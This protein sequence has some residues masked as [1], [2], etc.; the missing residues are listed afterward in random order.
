MRPCRC[1]AGDRRESLLNAA[2]IPK[3][4]EKCSFHTFDASAS[5]EHK[6]V[7]MRLQRWVKDFPVVEHGWLLTGPCGVGKT[8]LAV[9]VIREL[10]EAKEISC[11]FYEFGD[12]L[13]K[14]QDSYNPVSEASEL[15]VLEPLYS[16]DVLVLD[17][18][19]ATKPTDWVRDTMMQVI[20]RRYNDH[21]VTIFTSNY[22][23]DRRTERDETLTDRIGAR[24]RSRLYEMC[25]IV[26][27]EGAD[28]RLKLREERNKRP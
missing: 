3:R 27:V 13:K 16:V 25:E 11:L 18:L 28:Y 5:L 9:S 23:D 26:A 14:I 7:L 21:K 6:R 1:R 17:E 12:L 20:N 8:H 22:A 10:I 2:R 4:Y 15:K 19:G 24:L